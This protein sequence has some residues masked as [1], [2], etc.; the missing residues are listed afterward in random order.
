MGAGGA[1][2]G[3]VA[4]DESQTHCQC[5]CRHGA[6]TMPWTILATRTT[7]YMYLESPSNLLSFFNLAP[8]VITDAH[9]H[10]Y[11]AS[12]SLHPDAEKTR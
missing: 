4:I 1:Q 9:A 10:A 11:T 12:T 8:V 2:A 7:M 3:T 5:A 6:P